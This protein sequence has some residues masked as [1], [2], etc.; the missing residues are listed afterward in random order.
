[1]D[2][3]AQAVCFDSPAKRRRM[4]EFLDRRKNR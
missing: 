3:L 1:V 2:E 4:D